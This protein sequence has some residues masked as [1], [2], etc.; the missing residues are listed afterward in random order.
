MVRFGD[1]NRYPPMVELMLEMVERHYYRVIY[2]NNH[3][4]PLF[5][6]LT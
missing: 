4:E 1:S 5:P 2:G 3:S 6:D